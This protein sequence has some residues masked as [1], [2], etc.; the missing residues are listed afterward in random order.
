MIAEDSGVCRDVCSNCPHAC[1]DLLYSKYQDLV[2]TWKLLFTQQGGEEIC[3]YVQ[4]NLAD[5]RQDSSEG[6]GETEDVFDEHLEEAWRFCLCP[7]QAAKPG[8]CF[9]REELWA[10]VS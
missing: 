2:S 4:L 7:A 1:H 8:T 6:T 10:R 3:I 5:N 9:D